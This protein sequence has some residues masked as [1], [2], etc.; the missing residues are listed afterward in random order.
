MEKDKFAELFFYP[1]EIVKLKNYGPL[2]FYPKDIL[3]VEFWKLWSLILLSTGKD[4]SPSHI[5]YRI[6]VPYSSIPWK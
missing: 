1:Q 3:V 4:Y 6:M 5:V 2:F